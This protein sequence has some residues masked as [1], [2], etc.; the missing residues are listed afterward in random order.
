MT[1]STSRPCCRNPSCLLN[2]IS[3]MTSNA[4]AH[5]SLL[6]T[7]SAQNRCLTI[8]QPRRN[9]KHIPLRCKPIQPRK[10]RPYRTIHKRLE[11]GNR[12]HRIRRRHRSFNLSMKILVKGC[13]Q[14]SS[15]LSLCKLLL[16]TIER[17]LCMH[18]LVAYS[19][20]HT[21]SSKKIQLEIVGEE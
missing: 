15:R 11:L 20:K 10:E 5:V 7:T 6:P 13:K 2:V 8:L 18:G 1:P 16:D 21:S 4:S 3:P 17:R 19:H 9:I 14:R 12:A